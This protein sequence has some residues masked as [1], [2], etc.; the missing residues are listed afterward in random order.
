M[1]RTTYFSVIAAAALTAT[2][3]A[4]PLSAEPID[5]LTFLTFSG[6]SRFP[7]PPSTQGRYRFREA[8]Q[9]QRRDGKSCRFS[10]MTGQRCTRCSSPYPHTE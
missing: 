9:S 1:A 10:A 4:A 8:G 7:A 2:M 3:V 6:P 5:R